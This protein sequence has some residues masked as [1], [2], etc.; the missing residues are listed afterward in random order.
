MIPQAGCFPNFAPILLLD[1]TEKKICDVK[2]GDKVMA[3]DI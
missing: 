3:Y 2:I 1:G